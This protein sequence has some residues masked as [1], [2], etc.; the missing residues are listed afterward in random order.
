MSEAC[1]IYCDKDDVEKSS[2]FTENLE[3]IILESIH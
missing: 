1:S 2:D 3:C